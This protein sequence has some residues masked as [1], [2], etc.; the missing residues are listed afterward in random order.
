MP[1]LLLAPQS[2]EQAA[3]PDLARIGVEMGEGPRGGTTHQRP[4]GRVQDL[5]ERHGHNVRT[6]GFGF[7]TY[8]AHLRLAD[9][10]YAARPQNS[11]AAGLP[12][13]GLLA[14]RPG[15]PPLTRRLALQGSRSDIPAG[16]KGA[17]D[18]LPDGRGHVRAF[19]QDL[20]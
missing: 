13:T 11:S 4:P 3:A 5:V 10:P 17:G 9:G 16:D 2:D 8:R 18:G 7:G 14:A 15:S 6:P 19:E 12:G 1:I 20:R